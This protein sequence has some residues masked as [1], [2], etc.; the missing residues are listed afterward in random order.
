MAVGAKKP[1]H[2]D[3]AFFLYW[4]RAIAPLAGEKPIGYINWER[5]E[6]PF[7]DQTQHYMRGW[8][9]LLAGVRRAT[10]EDV[11][12]L[13]WLMWPFA[14]MFLAGVFLLARRCGAPPWGT[15]LLCA[16]SPP[17]LLPA[18]SLMADIPGMGLG[19]LGLGLWMAFPSTGGRIVAAL[20]L[21]LGAQMKQT[22]LV[23]FPLL[24]FEPSGRIVRGKREWIL[25]LGA[26]VL[27]GIYPDVPPH[28]REGSSI[29]AHVSW[30]LQSTWNPGLIRPKVSYLLAAC[31]ALM[32]NPPALG[33]SLLG[34]REP[35]P[36]SRYKAVVL[37]LLALPVLAL[38]GFWKAWRDG[39]ISLAATPGSRNDLWFFFAI[40][41]FIAWALVAFR[42]RGRAD[43]GGTAGAT[44]WLRLWLG[45]AA[46]GFLG[47]TFFPTARHLIA[48]MPA[49]AMIFLSD[50]RDNAGPRTARIGFALVLA[51]NFWLGL[52]LAR[53]DHV[54]AAWDRTAAFRG[55]GIAG[56]KHLPLVTTGSW[57]LRYY[58]ELKGGRVLE[59]ATEP[60]AGGAVILCP[61]FTDHR[62]L[63]AALRK[64]GRIVETLEGPAAPSWPWLPVRTIPLPRTVS[65]FHGGHV[66]FP[67]A[68]SRL[69]VETIEVI[70]LGRLSTARRGAR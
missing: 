65:S 51:G 19:M 49:L 36:G 25:F 1:V 68:F 58:T 13:H 54:F 47:A 48:L 5:F 6:E 56:A 61:R 69:S 52:S 37:G 30:I 46:A 26:L 23:L 70:E 44:P 27:A 33:W 42:R 34:R 9:I 4:A 16:A 35:G 45:F 10:G 14:T 63:P 20:L 43:S 24:L 11:R 22:V 53:S 12:I 41:V 40:A 57:G 62:V 38:A 3:D 66:W 50:L 59:N 60:L 7:R 28:D 17:F 32:L 67:Y 29:F 55:A 64:R 21:A 18:A 15:M 31:G 2:V 39:R 8:A